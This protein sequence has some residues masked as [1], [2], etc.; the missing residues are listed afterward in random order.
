[1]VYRPGSAKVTAAIFDEFR[2]LLE[3]LSL[4]AMP[5]V[6]TGYLNMCFDRPEDPMTLLKKT[7]STAARE[8]WVEALGSMHRLV[9]SK[10]VRY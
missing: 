8:H 3:F 10:R 2:L 7:L 1:M 9:R 6:I 5:Y 4:F